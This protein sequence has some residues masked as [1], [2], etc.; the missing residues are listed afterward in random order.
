MTIDEI[1]DEHLASLRQREVIIIETSDYG[2][3][4]HQW[5]ADSV[6]PTSDYDTPQEAAA[7]AAQ[8]LGIKEPVVPQNWPERAC[9]GEVKSE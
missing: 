5:T 6:M 8:L 1:K 4:V 7:R 2:Y 3:R 9:I